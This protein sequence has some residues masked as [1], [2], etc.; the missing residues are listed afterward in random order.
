MRKNRRAHSRSWVSRIAVVLILL[1][2]ENALVPPAAVRAVVP[3]AVYKTCNALRK[4]YELGVAAS[5]KA[6]GDYPADVD[7]VVYR[8]N[9]RLDI[10]K[11]GIACE[12]E[13]LQRNL[14]A[15]GFPS[16]S[17]TTTT[18]LRQAVTTTSQAVTTTTQA[19][20]VTRRTSP[21]RIGLWEKSVVL[22]RGE[23]YR[24]VTCANGAYTFKQLEVLHTSLGWIHKAQDRGEYLPSEC[25][26]PA[27]PYLVTLTWNVT[28]LPGSITKLRVT[29]FVGEIVMTVEII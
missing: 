16:Q 9:A 17:S 21:S 4:S 25:T 2:C 13:Q 10:D 19:A 24:F 27:Y 11:D 7:R 23:T 14:A 18:T 28:D 22:I 6:A 29:G 1:L 26:D 20:R 15:G 3:T 5:I 12:D 8:K